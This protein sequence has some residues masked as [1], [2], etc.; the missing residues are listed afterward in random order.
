METK[1]GAPAYVLIASGAL[2]MLYS[3]IYGVWTLIPVAFGLFAGINSWVQETNTLGAAL[4]SAILLSMVPILQLLGFC[5]TFVMAAIT[6][7][8]GVR[9]NS[10][11]SKGL[12]ALAILASTGAPA[13]ALFI[14]A[15]SALNLGSCGLG[16]LT[17]CLLGNIPT[18]VLL[19]VGLVASVF[20]AVTLMQPDTAE[21]FAMA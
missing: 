1:A 17:G 19:V 12:V 6:T 16:C 11:R 4:T 21:R 14:N 7:F 15:G 13:L 2:M 3:L 18:A 8:G 9:L 20:G 5:V 10:Y